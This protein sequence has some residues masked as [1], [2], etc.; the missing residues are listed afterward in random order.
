MLLAG[1]MARGCPPAWRGVCV[2]VCL[3][4]RVHVLRVVEVSSASVVVEFPGVAGALAELAH[5]VVRVRTARLTVSAVSA[6][7][8]RVVHAVLVVQAQLV[9]V[10]SAREEVAAVVRMGQ[11]TE[12]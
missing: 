4:L 12:A 10:G 6:T 3:P 7:A 9:T 5:R 8:Q 1:A 11:V 2:C